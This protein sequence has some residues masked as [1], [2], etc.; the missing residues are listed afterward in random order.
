[1][2]VN[3]FDFDLPP[4]RI[5][6][7]PAEPRDA[8]RLLVV[9]PHGSP[10]FEDRAVLDLPDFFAPGDVLAVNDTQVI[11]ARLHGVRAR[12]KILA[13]IE[14]TLFRREGADLWR[15]FARP[16]KKLKEGD[17]IR[18]AAANGMENLDAEV[19]SKGGEGEVLLK[20]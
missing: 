7:R 1:M 15:A 2:R 12:G 4:E 19:V 10:R 6:L 9:R 3:L 16:A 8:A 13:R 11:R 5:A 14:A 18:F 17:G 20:F